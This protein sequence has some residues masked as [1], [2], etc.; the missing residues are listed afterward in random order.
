MAGYCGNSRSLS[1]HLSWEGGTRLDLSWMEL[2]GTMQFV[3]VAIGPSN[4]GFQRAQVHIF[5]CNFP[6][7]QFYTAQ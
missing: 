3:T 7:E 1:A 5:S 4:C 2:G 6:I